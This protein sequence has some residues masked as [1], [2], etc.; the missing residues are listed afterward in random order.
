MNPFQINIQ[1]NLDWE[2]YEE[3]IQSEIKGAI[4]AEIRKETVQFAKGLR[5]CVRK[6][7]IERQ[8][9]WIDKTITE[10]NKKGEF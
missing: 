8:Q 6:Q 5:E 2:T 3:D 10:L 1:L 4:L 7:L 9:E